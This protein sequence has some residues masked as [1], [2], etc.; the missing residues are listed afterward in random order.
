MS[1]ETS[2][3]KIH[4]LIYLLFILLLGGSGYFN[5][6]YFMGKTP[7]SELGIEMAT[8]ACES[9]GQLPKDVRAQYVDAVAYHELKE[10]Y[11]KLEMNQ[12]AEMMAREEK[13]V[14]RNIPVKEELSQKQMMSDKPMMSADVTKVKDFAKCYDM[15]NAGHKISQ[16][17]RK[18]IT[19]YV[20]RHKDAHYFE[21]ISLIDQGEFRLFGQIESDKALMKKFGTNKKLIE[22]M[23]KL[24]QRGLGKNR[25]SEASWVIKAHTKQKAATYNANYELI[26]K[27]GYRGVIVRAYK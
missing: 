26:S 6:L 3:S 21:I 25:A 7:P 22:K 8:P 23:K 9:F 2:G 11:E 1:D 19:S 5:Y 13:S 16:K 20:D 12:D 15:G 18:A 17:C 4:I 24:T 10:S 14:M 27:K